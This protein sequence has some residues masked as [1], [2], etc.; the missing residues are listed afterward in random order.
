MSKLL[1]DLCVDESKQHDQNIQVDTLKFEQD[2]SVQADTLSLQIPDS[3][4]YLSNIT[5]PATPDEL[6]D[7]ER[8][9]TV[10]ILISSSELNEKSQDDIRILLDET[11][12]KCRDQIPNVEDS[13]EITDDVSFLVNFVDFISLILFNF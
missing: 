8:D 3:G 4:V 7:L 10:P 13:L 2:R 11:I 6:P 1:D 9:I 5:S 12:E